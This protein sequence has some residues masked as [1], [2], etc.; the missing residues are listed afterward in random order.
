VKTPPSKDDFVKLMMDSIRQS[1][2]KGKIV[3]KPEDFSLRGDGKGLG[4]YNAWAMARHDMYAEWMLNKR[5][6][7]E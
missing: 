4:R 3:Y 6:G 2:G 7:A 1:G 5:R